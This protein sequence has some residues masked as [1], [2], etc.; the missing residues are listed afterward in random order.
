[1]VFAFPLCVRT[2]T[3]KES[4]TAKHYGVQIYRCRSIIYIWKALGWALTSYRSTPSSI[5]VIL[6][7]KEKQ[8]SPMLLDCQ[9]YG[10]QLRSTAGDPNQPPQQ[11]KYSSKRY[12]R[13][14]P[15]MAS[16]EDSRGNWFYILIPRA[17]FGKKQLLSELRSNYWPIRDVYCPHCSPKYKSFFILTKL[18]DTEPDA[19]LITPRKAF[20]LHLPAASWWATFTN[21]DGREF[22]SNSYEAEL[23]QS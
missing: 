5:S 19:S 12:V 3:D 23:W 1:M 2:R 10:S 6:L 4:T 9:Q 18:T 17:C 16:A 14:S 8:S 11:D 22:P 13:N 20:H 7:V 21:S 15:S